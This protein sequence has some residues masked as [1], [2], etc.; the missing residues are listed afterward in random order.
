MPERVH[1]G[2]RVLLTSA[3]A[4]PPVESRRSRR[5]G[6]STAA[7]AVAIPTAADAAAHPTAVRASAP[8]LGEPNS[9]RPTKA[10]AA[11]P[12]ALP[13]RPTTVASAA[14]NH[15]SLSRAV[16]RRFYQT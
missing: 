14:A 2:G 8:R 9:V 13:A 6:A 7:A 4:V 3:L 1:R 16:P 11:G 5:A 10:A 12:A 15:I